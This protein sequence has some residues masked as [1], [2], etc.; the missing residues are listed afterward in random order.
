MSELLDDLF[1]GLRQGGMKDLHLL[2]EELL[3]P[4]VFLDTVVDELNGELPRD[5]YGALSLL[6]TVEPCLCPPHD[7]VAVGI[8]ADPS[9]DVEALDVDLE[10]GKGIDDTLTRYSPL[11]SFFLSFSVIEDRK[12]LCMSAR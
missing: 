1:A 4:L 10:V 8:D 6:V 3:Q 11:S 2:G 9:L 12:T 7:A 5:L